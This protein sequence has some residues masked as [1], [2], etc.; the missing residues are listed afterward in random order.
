MSLTLTVLQGP[1]NGHQFMVSSER[2]PLTFGRSTVAD[3]HVPDEWLSDRHFAVYFDGT[4]AVLRDLGSA[5]GTYVNGI[6]VSE[7][8]LHDGDQVAAGQSFFAV[9]LQAAVI[10]PVATDDDPTPEELVAAFSRSSRDRVRWALHDE[11]LPLFA[12]VDVA[13]E[14]ELLV[15][16]NRSGEQFCALDESV[17]PEEPGELNPML[18]TLSS[19]TQLLADVVEE[20]WGRGSTV[21][22]AS[23]QPF[24]EVY[25]HL[26]AQTEYDNEGAVRATPF[27]KPDVLYETLARCD[28]DE[29]EEFFGPIAAYLAEGETPEELLRFQRTDGGVEVQTVSIDV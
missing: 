16:I 25:A 4:N 10:V 12:V 19:D 14:P 15:K 13:K 21:F 29:A 6:G 7:V 11:A 18:V 5:H 26:V 27:H 17:D 8:P 28:R 9:S 24:H 1:A 2:S 22:L 3:V 23:N 20:A